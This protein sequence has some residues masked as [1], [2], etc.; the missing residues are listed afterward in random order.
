MNTFYVAYE[1]NAGNIKGRGEEHETLIQPEVL[2]VPART[3]ENL[4]MPLRWITR[5]QKDALWSES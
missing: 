3:T 4:K 5:Q 2:G 1:A